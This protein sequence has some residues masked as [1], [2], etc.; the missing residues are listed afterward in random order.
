MFVDTLVKLFVCRGLFRRVYIDC[1]VDFTLCRLK[2]QDGVELLDVVE[3]KKLREN[4]I[5]KLEQEG[6]VTTARVLAIRQAAMGELHVP[7][8]RSVGL[9]WRRQEKGHL[10][11]LL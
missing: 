8:W 6:W 4:G 2:G 1:T 3:F 10:K 5:C 9:A 7:S 11:P